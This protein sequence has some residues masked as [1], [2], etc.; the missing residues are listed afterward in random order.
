MQVPMK[1]VFLIFAVCLM[2]VLW[3]DTFDPES[4]RNAR[5]LVT[6]ASTGI[7]EQVAYHYAKMGAQ[8]V[9][10]ARR[11]YALQKVAANCTSLGAQKALYVTGDMSQSSDPER[12]VRMA[13][14]QLGGL[15]ILVLNHIGS[16]P[17][18]MWNGDGDHVRELMQ[19]NF[20]SYVNMASAALPVLEQSAGSMIVVS[21]LLGKITTPFVGPYAATKFAVNGFF[22]SM[23]HELAMQRSNVSLTIT[24]LGLIDTDSAMDK[25]RGYTNMTAYP[26]SDAALHIIK[27][28]A[29]HQKESFYPGYIYFVCLCRDWFPFFRDIIIQNSYTY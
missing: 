7:G 13:V 15:D 5:V 9:I 26:A 21:S 1:T 19:L 29:T 12:V 2:A 17:F 18:A 11:E 6:G 27:A 3:R 28:G 8:I 25:I 20:L 24:T 23:Q 22:G 10:T 4:V 14:E 16:T